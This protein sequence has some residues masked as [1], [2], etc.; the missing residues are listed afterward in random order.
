MFMLT[1]EI[2]GICYNFFITLC[3]VCHNRDKLF[4]LMQS[5]EVKTNRQPWDI[6]LLF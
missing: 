2:E 4:A 3:A 1:C 6:G 5:L